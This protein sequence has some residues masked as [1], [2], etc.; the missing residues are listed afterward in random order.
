MTN[1]E[2]EK[3]IYEHMKEIRKIH[4]QVCKSDDYLSLAVRSDGTITFNNTWW[5]LPKEEQIDFSMEEG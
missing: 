4:R 1:R 2:A 5:E 3:R